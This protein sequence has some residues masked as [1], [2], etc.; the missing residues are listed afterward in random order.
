MGIYISE[1][2]VYDAIYRFAVLTEFSGC[3]FATEN[4]QLI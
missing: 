4:W 3:F 2:I 1:C